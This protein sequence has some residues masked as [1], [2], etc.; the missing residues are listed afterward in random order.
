MQIGIEHRDEGA[1][2]RVV[3]RSVAIKDERDP[4]GQ[5]P[6]HAELLGSFATSHQLILDHYKTLSDRTKTCLLSCPNG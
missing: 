1:H 5:R 3:S 4:L 6:D 2:R